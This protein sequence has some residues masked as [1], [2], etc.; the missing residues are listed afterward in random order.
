MAQKK[1]INKKTQRY[2][3]RLDRTS[4]PLIKPTESVKPV[5]VNSVTLPAQPIIKP[6]AI[7]PSGDFNIYKGNITSSGTYTK[8]GKSYG[9]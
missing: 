5:S 7:D 4:A 6:D 9:N 2:Q 8:K 1:T 3:Q